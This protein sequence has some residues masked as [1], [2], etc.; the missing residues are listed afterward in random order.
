M[1]G[2]VRVRIGDHE[3]MATVT[4]TRVTLAGHGDFELLPGGDGTLRGDGPD[5]PFEAIAAR[6]RDR[7]WIGLDGDVIEATIASGAKRAGASAADQ[8]ALAAPMAATV[9]R[10]NVAPGAS[11]RN[12]DLLIALE[13]M[14]MELP[15][16]APRDGVV[17]A[18]HCREGELVQQGAALIDLAPEE[19]GP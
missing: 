8:D 14:K 4:G 11:I 10:V 17:A 19:P 3:F 1:S 13:A 2:R 18:V 16:R 9:V 7:V 5:G 6:Q 12:G 15:I